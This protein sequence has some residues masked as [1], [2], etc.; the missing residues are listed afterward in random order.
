VNGLAIKGTDPLHDNIHQDIEDYY[1]QQVLRGNGSFLVI[2]ENFESFE[3]AMKKK[4][5]KEIVPGA[6]GTLQ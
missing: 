6:V 1:R 4:L 5:L 3:E 2:A